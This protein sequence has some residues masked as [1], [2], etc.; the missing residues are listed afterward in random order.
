MT[1]YVDLVFLLNIF[2]D[3]ILLMSVSVIL[4]RNA[5]LLRII[6][7]S[8]I[9]GIS[10]VLLFI[11]V[12]SIVSLLLKLLLGLLMVIATFGYQG[13]KYTFNNLFYLYT[14][15][16]SVGGVM[17]LLMEK[18]YYNYV[19]LIVGFT[20]VLIMYI[21]QTKTYQ[22]NYA[23][24]YPVEIYLKDKKYL[25]TGFLDTGN[26]LYD[27]YKHRP[28]IIID[29]KIKY[30]L[31]DIIYVP[32]LSLNNRSVLK[33]LKTD[34]V[35]INNCVFKNYLVGLSNKKINI[36]GINCIL[37]SKMKGDLHA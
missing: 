7:G 15:S 35:I 28:V 8:L 23:N 1:I 36:D 27:S 4:T 31:E 3:F 33:C 34:K 20:I 11:N 21:K 32:Y 29:K 13:I 9:G 2:L 14:L 12:N 24:Y 17:Y 10:T 30:N 19:V 25:L 26:K 16:F 37:H 22:D 5:K 18:G 6:L